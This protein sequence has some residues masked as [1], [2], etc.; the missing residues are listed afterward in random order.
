[1][2]KFSGKSAIVI[3]D[4]SAGTPRTISADVTNYDIE[5][6]APGQDVTG[7]G[8]GNINYIPGQKQQKIT[9][10]VLWNTAA[11]TGAMTVLRGIVGSTT[12]KTVTITPEGSGLAFS[13]EFM[14]EGITPSG[15]ADGAPIS[16]GTVSFLPMG[17]VAAAWA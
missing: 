2:A 4:D 10:T 11:T 9:L 15:S 8:E 14:C 13:G 3:V 16:L 12:S 7:F 5:D 1:M 17:G 6:G